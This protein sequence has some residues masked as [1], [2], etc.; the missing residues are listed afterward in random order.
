MCLVLPQTVR[1]GGFHLKTFSEVD[2]VMVAMLCSTFP[3]I[4]P[5][6]GFDRHQCLLSQ[7]AAVATCSCRRPEWRSELSSTHECALVHA[8]VR[9]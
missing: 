1:G 7:P 3:V 8:K 6:L 9:G 2:C 4:P 5:A